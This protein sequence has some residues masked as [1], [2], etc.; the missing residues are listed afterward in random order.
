MN[1]K[2]AC[3]LENSSVFTQTEWTILIVDDET[4][5]R[6]GLKR[7]LSNKYPSILLASDGQVAIDILQKES[8]DLVLLDLNMPNKTGIDV[9][10]YIKHNRLNTLS[11]VISGETCVDRVTEAIKLGAHDYLRK[12]YCF[13]ELQHTIK[14]AFEKRNIELEKER[15]ERRLLTSEKLHRYLVEHSPDLI[16]IL[17]EQGR[18][19]FVNCSFGRILGYA[20]NSILGKRLESLVVAE[21]KFKAKGISQHFI[22]NNDN[23]GS[24]QLQFF[25]ANGDLK[26]FDV[27][28]ST[29]EMDTLAEYTQL[30]QPNQEYKAIYCVARDISDRKEAEKIITFQAYHD[31]LTKLPNR[32][33]LRDRLE[34]AM[35]QASRSNETLVLMFLDLDRFKLINDSFGH[36]VGDELLVR[37]SQRLKQQIRNGDTLAR[38]SGDEFLLLLPQP[39]TREQAEQVAQ[40][41]ITCLQEPFILY[42][43]EV[44]VN[45]SIGITVFPDDCS[46]VDEIIQ[47][48]DKAMYAV[49]RSG[50]NGYCFYSEQLEQEAEKKLSIESGLRRA[51]KQD[52]FELYYQPQVDAFTGNIVGV[53]A[54]IRWLHPEYGMMGPSYFIEQAE[55]SG[56][57]EQLSEWMLNRMAVDLF[58][59]PCFTNSQLKVSVN[60]SAI[61]ISKNNFPQNILTLL[62]DYNIAPE[63]LVIEITENVLM[64]DLKAGIEKLKRLSDSGVSISIDD[65]GTGYSSLNY[66]RKLPVHGVKIDRAFTAEIDDSRKGA[67][68]IS[69]I[70]GMAH[71]LEMGVIAEG[72]ETES[73]AHYLRSLGCSTFQGFLYSRPLSTQQL[74]DVIKNQQ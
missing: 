5:S 66:L 27:S 31:L 11:I 29:V 37:L 9:L 3:D 34:L 17:D 55:D 52:E 38:L 15:V 32:M 65:F 10:S 56:L 57:I 19:Q 49:K 7:L 41:L 58:N 72:V 67:N 70:V 39:I 2:L 8:I 69:A 71:G 68:L 53:E 73:Q 28:T 12:P 59:D 4:N 54:L 22:V 50:K 47:K 44:Y 74:M 21:D 51:L 14:N 16:F 26:T 42:D 30:N 64:T 20:G 60:L 43:K 63:R 18:F 36:A 61:D 6:R 1:Y 40:K 45:I 62:E 13:E 23:A 24:V 33:L 48:A 35:H 46:E 25:C